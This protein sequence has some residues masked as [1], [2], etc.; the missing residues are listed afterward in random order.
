MITNT[1]DVLQTST[2]LNHGKLRGY[3]KLISLINALQVS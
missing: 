1:T 2:V 3:E